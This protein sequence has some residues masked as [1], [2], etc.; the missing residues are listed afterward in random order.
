[1]GTNRRTQTVNAIIAICFL[2]IVTICAIAFVAYLARH[3][4]KDSALLGAKSISTSTLDSL[5]VSQ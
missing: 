1:M 3:T 2:L 5:G 4:P